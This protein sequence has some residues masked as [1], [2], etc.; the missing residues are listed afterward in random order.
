MGKSIYVGNIPLRA[1]ADDLAGW[2]TAF[3]TVTGAHVVNDRATGRALGF[4]LVEMGDG[5]DAAI[6]ALH[7]SKLEGR[8]LTVSA[9]RPRGQRPAGQARRR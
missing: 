3:G 5:G 6:A 4:G 1:T 7:G 2:F 9:S 8:T